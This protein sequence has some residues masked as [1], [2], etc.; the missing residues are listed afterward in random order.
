[1]NADAV[2]FIICAHDNPAALKR[3]VSRLASPWARVLVHIDKKADIA[4]FRIQ[5]ADFIPDGKRVSILW[6]GSRHMLAVLNCLRHALQTYPGACR[7]VMLSAADYPIKPLGDIRDFLLANEDTDF[8]RVGRKVVWN[9]PT[10]QDHNLKFH[11]GDIELFNDRLSPVP[12]MAAFAR[13]LAAKIPRRPPRGYVIYHGAM[14]WAL[15]RKGAETVLRFADE[16][17]VFMR[18]IARARDRGEHFVQTALKAD[19]NTVIS[20]DATRGDAL[21]AT[22]HGV[23]YI[24][25]SAGGPHPKTLGL[26]DLPALVQTSALFARKFHP[27]TSAR[28]LDALDERIGR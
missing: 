4:D 22:L 23:H 5:D 7:F 27:A 3:L 21:P 20:Q 1:M 8:I 26:E 2:V 6:G 24:D 17:T 19:A 14:W 9:G 11:I 18:W 28:V 13:K 25:W 15:S 10:P 12:K 16:N